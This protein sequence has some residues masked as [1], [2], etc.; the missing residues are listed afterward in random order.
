MLADLPRS[1]VTVTRFPDGDVKVSGCHKPSPARQPKPNPK[2]SEIE[3]QY[4]AAKRA[5]TV[6]RDLAKFFQ[7]SYLLT[8]TYRGPVVDRKKVCKDFKRFLRLVRVSLPDFDC[9]AV[10]E[11]HKG[12]GANDGG[13]H[14]HLATDRFHP[15]QVL[16]AAWW[17]IV[18]DGQGNIQIEHRSF[19]DSF[20]KVGAYLAKYIAKDF[21]SLPRAFGEHRYLRSK[22]FKMVREK[23]VFFKGPFR[24]HFLAARALA[25]FHSTGSFISEWVSEDGWQ[26][27]FK[28]YS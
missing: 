21:D 19:K 11:F 16:R 13:I 15:V 23:F 10:L 22:A 4:I 28:S 18:G 26:F 5:A 14:L 2:A 27:V 17:E 8:L 24:S 25:I 3:K 12:G 7:L 9:L 6:V 1:Y 20:R